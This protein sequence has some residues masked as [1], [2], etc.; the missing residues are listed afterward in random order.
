MPMAIGLDD[1]LVLYINDEYE[2]KN[3]HIYIYTWIFQGVLN[4]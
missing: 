3:T 2:N 1:Q 4:G